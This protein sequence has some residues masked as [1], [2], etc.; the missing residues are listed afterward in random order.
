MQE[1]NGVLKIGLRPIT[2]EVNFTAFILTD[3]DLRQFFLYLILGRLPVFVEFTVPCS[4]VV[5]LE[6]VLVRNP[7]IWS[8]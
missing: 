1:V 8:E 5:G 3:R 2:C 4:C 6:N 7:G